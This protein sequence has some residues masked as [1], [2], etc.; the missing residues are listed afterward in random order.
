MRYSRQRTTYTSAMIG[1]MAVT[2]NKALLSEIQ[3]EKNPQRSICQ[4]MGADYVGIIYPMLTMRLICSKWQSMI[5]LKY[6]L[7]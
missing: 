6:L 3:D 5:L 4:V 1:E 2:E 7:V